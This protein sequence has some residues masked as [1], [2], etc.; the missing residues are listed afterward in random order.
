MELSLKYAYTVWQEKSF[1]SA[2][3][4]LFVTQPA[5]SATVARLE[6]EL[7]FKIFDRTTNPISLTPQGSI[8]MDYLNEIAEKENILS[9]RLRAFDSSTKGNIIIRGR[10]YA[11]HYL[12]P[13][14]CGEFHRKY[15]HINVTIDMNHSSKRLP[16]ENVD[17]ILSYVKNHLKEKT[18]PI[19]EERLVAAIH[20]DHPVAAEL[21]QYAVSFEEIISKKIPKEKEIEDT[22]IFEDVPFIESGV[23]SDS[24]QRRYK[25]ITS[26]RISPFVAP[27]YP[28]YEFR[29]KLM[30]QRL[31]AV[32]I[33]DLFL[34]SLVNREEDVLFFAFK[35]PLSFRTLYISYLENQ[36]NNEILNNF[37]STVYECLKNNPSLSVYSDKYIG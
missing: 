12:L 23:G 17:V 18:V 16:S 3:K 24:D 33:A 31:G 7:G 22:S 36:E 11:A 25:M 35:S 29:Y 4:I 15:P 14:I 13:L 34:S 28:N 20:K 6:K 2:A 26:N 19:I 37:I 10:M 21:A 32:L 30:K 5:L 27:N 9:Q 1:S 8:Y